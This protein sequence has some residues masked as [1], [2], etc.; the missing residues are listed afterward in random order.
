MKPKVVLA[1]LVIVGL[2]GCG[3]LPDAHLASND[4]PMNV[5][6]WKVLDVATKYA[7][8]TLERLKRSDPKFENER[9][10]IVFM[11]NVVVPERRKDIPTDY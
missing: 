8:E 7:P 3:D 2:A 5:E 9:N 1:L 6:M 4:Q 11:R 10:W